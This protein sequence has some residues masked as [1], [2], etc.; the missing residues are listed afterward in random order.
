MSRYPIFIFAFALVNFKEK[1]C[2]VSFHMEAIAGEFSDS[3][4][5]TWQLTHN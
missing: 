3:Q 1:F 2:L 5:A 4:M